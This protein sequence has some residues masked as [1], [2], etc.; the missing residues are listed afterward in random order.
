MPG[1]TATTDPQLDTL[2]YDVEIYD[3]LQMT[4]L[5]EALTDLAEGTGT[6]EATPAALAENTQYAWRA[7]A[8]DPSAPG[9]GSTFSVSV[10]RAAQGL[11]ASPDQPEAPVLLPTSGVLDEL[12]E[13]ARRGDMARLKG[14]LRELKSQPDLQPFVE[15]ALAATDAFDDE[16]ILSLIN[17][18]GGDANGS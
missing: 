8:E 14:L 5:I 15:R 1:S 3:D 10:P 2:L 9:Q 4:T 11:T 6:T 12:T 16:G 13:L 18:N 17:N 7:R